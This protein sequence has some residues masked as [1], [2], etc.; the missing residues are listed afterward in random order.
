MPHELLVE[1]LKLLEAQ[2]KAQCA[3]CPLFPVAHQARRALCAFEAN[4]H[5]VYGWAA[6][7]SQTYARTNTS[8]S[9]VQ[10]VPGIWCR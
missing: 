1:A 6:A 5:T 2:G 7:L 9:Y 3:D 4:K 8:T 10:D